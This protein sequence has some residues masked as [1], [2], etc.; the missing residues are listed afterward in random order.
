MAASRM[1]PVRMA[2]KRAAMASA[3]GGN[4]T[5]YLPLWKPRHRRDP[6]RFG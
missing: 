5:C 4:A 1:A 3:A 2:A 6:G